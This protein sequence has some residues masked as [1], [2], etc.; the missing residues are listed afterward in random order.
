MKTLQAT[1]G[2]MEVFRI[3]RKGRI[4]IISFLYYIKEKEYRKVG[5]N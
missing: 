5:R 2:G 1:Q 3:N 4:L